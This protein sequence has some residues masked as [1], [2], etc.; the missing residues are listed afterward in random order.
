MGFGIS[1]NS[2]AEE[3]EQG[4]LLSVYKTFELARNSPF[5]TS[6]T[7]PVPDDL[8]IYLRLVAPCLFTISSLVDSILELIVQVL[9]VHFMQL[10]GKSKNRYCGAESRVRVDAEAFIHHKRG[11]TFDR[12]GALLVVGR[13]LTCPA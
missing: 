11:W 2:I 9:L 1:I 8:Q 10:A 12:E 3:E 4:L 13:H 7:Y 5:P 6:C